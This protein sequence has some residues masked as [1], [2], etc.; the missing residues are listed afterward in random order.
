LLKAKGT[1][2]DGTFSVWIGDAGI[3]DTVQRTRVDAAYVVLM[4]RLYAYGIPMVAGTD[5]E[6]SNS[7]RRELELFD[8][9]GIPRATILQMATIGSARVMRKERDYG[10]LAIGEFADVLVVNDDPAAPGRP[11]E[12]GDHD[13]RRTATRRRPAAT[14]RRRPR[15]LRIRR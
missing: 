9:A 2:V 6:S 1:V 8:V 14:I 13:A 3:A 15:G 11:C 4:R 5:V 7:H 12:T 10:N